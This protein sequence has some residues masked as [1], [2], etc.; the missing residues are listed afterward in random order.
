MNSHSTRAVFL[1]MLIVCLSFFLSGTAVANTVADGNVLAV[2]TWRGGAAVTVAII[3][4][5]GDLHLDGSTSS[6]DEHD[7]ALAIRGLAQG[8]AGNW[9]GEARYGFDELRELGVISGG[10]KERPFVSTKRRMALLEGAI[11]QLYERLQAVER[12]VA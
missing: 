10:D 1:W 11:G 4:E 7:D 2:R 6:Y 5:D 9:D 3:D 8:L 12:A